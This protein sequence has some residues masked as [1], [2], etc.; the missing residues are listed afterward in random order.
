VVYRLFRK[1]EPAVAEVLLSDFAYGRA[2]DMA[3]QIYQVDPPD[4]I[5]VRSVRAALLDNVSRLKIDTRRKYLDEFRNY[6]DRA[7]RTEQGE[8]GLTIYHF[9]PNDPDVPFIRV[10]DA[11]GDEWDAGNFP[12]VFRIEYFKDGTVKTYRMVQ[13]GDLLAVLNKPR[14][15]TRSCRASRSGW[16]GRPS[17]WRPSVLR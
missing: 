13:P 2:V 14:S 11:V 5:Q 17:S 3:R 1:E 7:T 16:K 10:E 6:R 15:G 8:E 9:D 12:T 4:F